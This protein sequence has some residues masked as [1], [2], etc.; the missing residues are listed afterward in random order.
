MDPVRK[1]VLVFCAFCLVLLLW[2]LFSDRFTPFTTQARVNA[3][4]VPI[5]PEVQGKLLAVDVTN[6]QFVTK[7]QRLVQIDPEKYDLAVASAE[8]RLALTLQ[9]LR[10]SSAAVDAAAAALESSR[11]ALVKQGQNASRLQRIMKEDPGAISQRLLEQAE[12]SLKEAEAGV[13]HAEAGLARAIEQ[14]GPRD[15]KN[16]QLLAARATLD[17]AR[18]D[19]RN[20]EVVA[21]DDGLV[22][23]LRVNVG[24]FATPGQPLMTFVAIQDF[25]VQ[26]DLTENNLGHVKPGDPVELVLDV[27]PGEVLQGKV[28]S[29]VWGVAPAESAS[30][31]GRLPTVQNTRN[32]LRDAQRFPVLIDIDNRVEAIKLGARVGSQADVVVYAGD[33]AILNALGRFLIRLTA[34]LSYAY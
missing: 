14:R 2:Y 12:A 30:T 29:I 32:W 23:D 22:T 34:I 26:A 17:Q 13:A 19:L 8:A 10:A 4:V 27:W 9:D 20:T 7:G 28:R 25:W 1:W 5:A 24:N 15:D 3:F 18:R 6:N 11:A 31:P 33:S 16:P 21:P